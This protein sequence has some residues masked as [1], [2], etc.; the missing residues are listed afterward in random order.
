MMD[1]M[2]SARKF[3]EI[4]KMKKHHLFQDFRGSEEQ[5]NCLV[6]LSRSDWFTDAWQAF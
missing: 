4:V 2:K 6:K 1:V 3:H 5:W